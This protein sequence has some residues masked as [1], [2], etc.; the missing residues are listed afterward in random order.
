MHVQ[1]RGKRFSIVSSSSQHMLDPSIL[2]IESEKNE[3]NFTPT[4]TGHAGEPAATTAAGKNG[5]N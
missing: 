4:H 2:D 3:G 5:E 1:S